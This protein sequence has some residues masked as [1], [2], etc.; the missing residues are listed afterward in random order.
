MVE[1]KWSGMAIAGFVLSFLGILAILGVIFSSIGIAQT[2][3]NKRKGRGLAIAGL[4]ISILVLI[5]T[6]SMFV[7]LAEEIEGTLGE[8]EFQTEGNSQQTPSNEVRDENKEQTFSLGDSIQAGDFKWKILK[9][10]KFNFIGSNYFKTEAD[11]IYLVLDVEI[12]NTGTTAEYLMDSYLKLV[13]NQ[14]REF[15]ADS[16]AAIYLD[17]GQAIFFDQINPG[18]VKKGKIVFDVPKDLEIVEVQIS[19]NLMSDSFYKINLMV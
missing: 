6:F 14:G 8:T 17:P 1:K 19:S 18:I 4:I 11:G 16:G 10:S 3:G 15:S 13:D 5:L 9:F 2:K 7:N 12:E